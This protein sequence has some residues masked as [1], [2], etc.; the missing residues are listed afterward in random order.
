MT[1]FT[2]LLCVFLL[3][4]GISDSS[5]FAQGSANVSL[6]A[7]IDDYN[8]Y[9]DCWGYTA[10]DGREYAL[11]GVTNGTSIIDITDSGNE[12][13][14]T[15]IPSS[16]STWKDIKTYRHYAYT[17][18]E[19]GGGLQIID[20]SD[21]PNS[22]THIGSYTNFTTSH[23]IYVDT[24]QALLFAEGS[25]GVAVRILSL[26]DPE[27]PVQL[28]TF[29]IECHDVFAEDGLAYVAEGFSGSIG[30]YSY[31]NPSSPQLVDRIN[32]PSAGY[33]HNTWNTSDGNYLM[34]T[35]ETTGKTVKMW[36]IQDLGNPDILST[37]LGPSRVAHNVT[38][39][40]DS[41]YISHYADGLIVLDISDKDNITEI[42]NYDTHNSTGGFNGAWGVFPFFA[43]GK[44]LISDISN[45]LFIFELEGSTGGGIPCN[46]ITTF[47]ARC[48]QSGVV[49]TRVLLNN[50][51]QYAG[52]TVEW[53]IDGELYS[54][55]LGTNGTHSRA[56]LS[57]SGLGAG[58]HSV[59]LVTPA[60]C[61][62]PVDVVCASGSARAEADWDE[63]SWTLGSGE[64]SEAA[65]K[66]LVTGLTGNYPNPFNPV[67]TINYALS[68][69]DWVSLK[70]YNTLGQEV[71]VLVNGFQQAGLKSAVWD[72]RNG[73]DR[74]VASGIYFARLAV[75]PNVTIQKMMFLK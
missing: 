68:E 26:A 41:A 30:I 72:V 65:T 19:S 4:A 23:N 61:F 37:Y 9:N 20:L 47:Q 45:G 16:N 42:A 59:E 29:G 31:A 57:V 71:A 55:I 53:L 67:T 7:H 66:P 12:Y 32:I 8:T 70:V 14:V 1:H 52:E 39:K 74:N 10:P 28:S 46:E 6:I 38:I 44:I 54:V 17:V 73:F 36:D 48:N 49:Q 51:T 22:A 27:N 5:L 40:G 64:I 11:L 13:E 18:T 3:V 35:E 60:S 75:G 63:D 34:S 43:S 50:S 21:L 33:V 25:G 56:Q 62:D 2:T 24:T 69:D 15:F 58:T